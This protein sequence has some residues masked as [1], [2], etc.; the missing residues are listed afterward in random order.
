MTL[1]SVLH[2]VLLAVSLVT[3]GEISQVNGLIRVPLLVK[4]MNQHRGWIDD[5]R[6]LN[7]ERYGIVQNVLERDRTQSHKELLAQPVNDPPSV[8]NSRQCD[9]SFLFDCSASRW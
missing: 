5:C 7:S 6:L 2:N 1:W 3:L 9:T 8:P 4:L